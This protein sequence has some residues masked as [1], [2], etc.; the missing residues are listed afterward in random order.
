MQGATNN[1]AKLS[2]YPSIQAIFSDIKAH[3]QTM[4]QILDTIWREIKEIQEPLTDGEK[5]EFFE[6]GLYLEIFGPPKEQ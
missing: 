4:Y 6:A 2:F 1:E 5:K 3:S